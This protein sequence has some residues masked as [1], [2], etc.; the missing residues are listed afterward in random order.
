MITL[1]DLK[2]L[3]EEFD[4]FS[5]VA[6]GH[7]ICPYSKAADYMFPFLNLDLTITQLEGLIWHGLYQEACV[8]ENFLTKEPWILDVNQA[9]FIVGE[10]ERFEKAARKLRSLMMR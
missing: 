4:F 8:C 10:P 1:S 5:Y 7:N 6:V 2:Y 9:M 3:L